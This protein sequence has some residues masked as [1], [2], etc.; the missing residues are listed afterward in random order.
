MAN[1]LMLFPY[2]LLC[3]EIT[4]KLLPFLGCALLEEGLA[5][6]PFAAHKVLGG[7]K[8]EE[9]PTSLSVTVE[10]NQP[11]LAPRDGHIEHLQFLSQLAWGIPLL[12]L[13]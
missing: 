7:H 3:K 1:D 13:M 2:Q 10:H 5:T 11:I 8:V 4:T 6:I 12:P 9:G